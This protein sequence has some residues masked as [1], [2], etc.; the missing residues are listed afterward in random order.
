MLIRIMPEFSISYHLQFLYHFPRISYFHTR[1]KTFFNF[2]DSLHYSWPAELK[3]DDKNPFPIYLFNEHIFTVSFF[4]KIFTCLRWS[5]NYSVNVTTLDFSLSFLFIKEVQQYDLISCEACWCELNHSN[6]FLDLIT[7]I[8]TWSITAIVLIPD[9][10][11][12]FVL[13]L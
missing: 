5:S 8:V 6:S 9:T 2:S 1:I 10:I 4:L 7:L 3:L 11:P 13:H 12:I